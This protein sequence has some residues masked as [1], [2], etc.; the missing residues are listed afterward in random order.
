MASRIILLNTEQDKS[1]YLR[2]EMFFIH[3]W[4]QINQ[5]VYSIG[6][7]RAPVATQFKVKYKEKSQ[8]VSFL[9]YSFSLFVNIFLIA[10]TLVM[11]AVVAEYISRKRS[12]QQIDN[13]SNDDSK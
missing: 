7:F 8:K 13:L 11:Q 10:K 1:K 4:L 12:W 6:T 2:D 3:Y 5:N 9:P